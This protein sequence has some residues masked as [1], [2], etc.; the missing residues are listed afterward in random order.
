[1]YFKQVDKKAG[2]LVVIRHS[3]E[4]EKAG[5][6]AE[7]ILKVCSVVP[8]RKRGKQKFSLHFLS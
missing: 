4:V 8:F 3:Q 6:Y 5:S 2:T 7:Q 1:M